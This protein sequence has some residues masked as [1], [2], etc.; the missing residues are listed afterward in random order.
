VIASYQPFGDAV[1][2][3]RNIRQLRGFVEELD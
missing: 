1:H 2:E 3:C